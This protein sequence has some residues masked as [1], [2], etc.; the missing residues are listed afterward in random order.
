MANALFIVSIILG[1]CV[2]LLAIYAG[3]LWQ[4]V[5]AER[6]AKREL[7]EYANN[8]RSEWIESAVYLARVLLAGQ[9]SAGE[10]A[11]RIQVLLDN[12]YP[13]HCQ[14]DAAKAKFAPFYQ[15]SAQLAHLPIREARDAL[16]LKTLRAQDR[17][18]ERL[19]NQYLEDLKIAARDLIEHQFDDQ[20]Y[21]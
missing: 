20:I 18:R 7:L 15:L 10:C 2:L 11:I 19:E 3:Y 14:S 8:K 9:T 1:I 4:R 6:R 17:E 13:N 16:D 12:I 21:T 5:F